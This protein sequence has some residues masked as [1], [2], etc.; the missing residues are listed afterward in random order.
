MAGSEADGAGW[1]SSEVAVGEGGAVESDADGDVGAVKEDLGSLILSQKSKKN[2][3][4]PPLGI[5][6]DDASVSGCSVFDFVHRC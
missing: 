1:E 4:R 5:K 3:S 2:F 6:W